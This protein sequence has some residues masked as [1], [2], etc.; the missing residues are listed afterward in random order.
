MAMNVSIKRWRCRIRLQ[1]PKRRNNLK[2]TGHFQRQ[3]TFVIINNAPSSRRLTT[4]SLWSVRFTVTIAVWAG[5]HVRIGKG[6]ELPIKLQAP[7]TL[8]R[9]ETVRVFRVWAGVDLLSRSFEWNISA[10]RS[11][12]VWAPLNT[13][14]RGQG[15]WNEKSYDY[16]SF[17]KVKKSLYTPWRRLGG[18]EV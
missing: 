9:A 6:G 3:V 17:L 1:Y 18:E 14:C 2:S 16:I 10:A 11:V 5:A 8:N 13:T 4:L 7:V 12:W 15:T